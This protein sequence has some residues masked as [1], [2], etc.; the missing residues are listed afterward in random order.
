MPI[1]DAYIMHDS[2]DIISEDATPQPKGLRDLWHSRG[3]KVCRKIIG[4]V[5]YRL[6]RL[7]GEITAVVLALGIAILWFGIT[8]VE[9]Q[10]TD[11]TALRP[12]IKLWF[13][14]AFDG[15]DAEF[16]RLEMAWLPSFDQLVVTIEDAE[17]KDDKGEVLEHFSLIGATLSFEAGL[18][19]RPSLLNAE[20]KGGV[21]SFIEDAQGNFTVGLG[22]PETVGQ[23]GPVFKSNVQ[24]ASSTDFDSMEAI[25]DLEFIHISDAEVFIRSAPSG[26][27]LRTEVDSLRTAF[28]NDADVT[29]DGNLT[30]DARGIIDQPS[31]DVPFEI[32]SVVDR[33]FE[34]IKFRVKANGMRPDEVAPKKG[35]F[36]ELQGIAA[37]VN[38]TAEVD[39]SRQRGLQAAALEVEIAN[40]EFVLLR[41]DEPRS[42][43]LDS[44]VARASLAPG[45]ERMDV[46]QLELNS[47]NLSFKAS[48]F[49]TQLGMLSDGDVNSSPSSAAIFDTQ[50]AF[51]G[52][53][54]VTE[55]NQFKALDFQSKM[56]GT[57]THEE[58]LM[59]W[60]VNTFDGARRWIEKSIQGGDLTQVE[61]R[62][63]FDE[64][65]FAAPS[66][67][68][69]RFQLLFAGHGFDVKYM[70]S[71]P[72]AKG[73]RGEGALI[74]NRLNVG[75]DGGQ[76]GG[77]A[78]KDGTV[79]IPVILPFGG[80][81]II[82]ADGSG[83]VPALLDVANN[84]P[85]EVASR[86]DID[87]KEVLGEGDVSL[88]VIFPLIANV[89]TDQLSY[90]IRGD[91]KGV[92]APFKVGQYDIKNGEISLDINRDRV[93][94]AGPA[95]VGPW[96]V[97]LSWEETFGDESE[98]AQYGVSGIINA[99][100][101]D[102]L[103]IASRTWFDGDAAIT[104]RAEGNG[105]DLKFAEFDLDL[106]NSEMSVEHIWLKPKGKAAHFLSQLARTSEGGYM[107]KNARLVSEGV[108]VK[109]QVELDA[110]FK[111]RKI[112]FTEM[113]ID[114]LIDGAVHI[115]PHQEAGRLGVEVDARYL[116]VSPWTENLF[117]ERFQAN[118]ETLVLDRDYIVSRSKLNF[119]HSGEVIEAAS[120]KALSDG[121]PLNLELKTRADSRR[122]VAVTI[123]DASK[124]VS[125]FIGLDNTKGG[126]LV[127]I[128]GLPAEGEEGAIIG[129]AE[130]LDF[131]VKEAP[132]LA[133]LLSIASLTGLADTL[134]NGSMQFDRFKLPFTVLGDD[135]AIRDARLYGP[136]L[137]MTGN[138]E[139]NLDKRVM[140]FDGT[141]VPAYN[142][143]SFLGE[144]PLIGKLFAQEKGGGLIALTYTASGP[145]EKTQIAVN[146]LSAL[147]PGF[148]RGIFKRDRTQVDEAIVAAIEDVAPP[149]LDAR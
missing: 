68:D 92:K 62:V 57:L 144:I 29:D 95:D 83:Q 116:D 1:G 136:A 13:A 139:L 149:E 15:R 100:L 8:I 47:P 115:T 78:I 54:S 84:P 82:K 145:F 71:M 24:T 108:N 127:I 135:I 123:P 64:T 50:H 77:V 76:L 40:G 109:G 38:L 53:L 7:I 128:A 146:P 42:Y 36:W 131:R 101:L 19:K 91:F 59:L 16:G 102:E 21:L 85:F 86:Y 11:L 26:I 39:F 33:N 89:S 52:G 30:F 118:V 73:V 31:G 117:A 61:A 3:V 60:P 134:T 130:M 67:T 94:I 104:V 113:Q 111:P 106:T 43:P 137:G 140:D 80:N 124:A 132:A 129:D 103:G 37:P 119:A 58:L 55:K 56:S 81:I 125:A 34:D 51:S 10:S 74:G 35:R 14:E 69:N 87:P 143:N 141:I 9:Q 70:Q 121:K 12:N 4:A 88:E 20:V 126:S 45:E 110:Y 138:G 5:I 65:F 96:K 93:I 28:S 122:E 114:S 66:L 6:Y 17:I 120:L 32:S 49:L 107:I 63:N 41:E 97:D 48:G 72:H 142:A 79:E 98:L 46:S 112:D 90:N 25:K 148:L 105:T 133:Q 27:D 2:P 147:T 18:F 75:F 99:D 23:V 44:L 22:P